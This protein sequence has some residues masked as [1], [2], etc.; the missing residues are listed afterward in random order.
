MLLHPAQL[1]S[2]QRRLRHVSSISARTISTPLA[3]RPISCYFTL[4]TSPDAPAFYTSEVLRHTLNPTWRR[5]DPSLFPPSVNQATTDFT[6][7]IWGS[8]GKE[9]VPLLQWDVDLTGLDYIGDRLDIVD[10]CYPPNTIIFGL[11]STQHKHQGFYS[12]GVDLSDVED[13]LP[14]PCSCVEVPTKKVVPSYTDVDLVRIHLLDLKMNAAQRQLADAQKRIED[15]LL[16]FLEDP[17]HERKKEKVRMKIAQLKEELER[18][19]RLYEKEVAMQETLSA[20][21]QTRRDAMGWSLAKYEANR[22][23]M[24]TCI[25]SLADLRMARKNTSALLMLRRQQLV[26]QLNLIF[27]MQRVPSGAYKILDVRLPSANDYTGCDEEELSTALGYVAHLVFMV[28][29]YLQL[30]LRYPLVPMGSR[31]SIISNVTSTGAQTFP[32]Y[33]KGVE[34]IRFEHAVFLLNRDVEQLMTYCGLSTPD[35]KDTLK[36]LKRLLTT[37][38]CQSGPFAMDDSGSLTSLAAVIPPPQKKGHRRAKSS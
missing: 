11:E 25:N 24:V 8:R 17:G 19:K 14:P 3:P 26:S 6:V 5:L 10:A 9:Y 33:A 13:K 34:R 2:Q 1:L 20:S 38:L 36:N 31:A 12:S 32:L 4:H 22:H 18:Q 28:S 37:D 16:G 35:L 21:N 15:N 29:R 23:Q 27:P 7:R 30:P